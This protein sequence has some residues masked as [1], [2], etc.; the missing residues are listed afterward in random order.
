M[1]YFLEGGVLVE[2]GT[3]EELMEMGGKYKA[4]VEEQG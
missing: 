3:H 1:I 2:H 4:L